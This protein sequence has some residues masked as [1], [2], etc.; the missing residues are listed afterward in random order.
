M[1]IAYR[2]NDIIF[3][4]GERASASVAATFIDLSEGVQH[5]GIH[6]KDILP[7]DNP[8]LYV[9]PFGTDYVCGYFDGSTYISRVVRP[10]ELDGV[11]GHYSPAVHELDEGQ[12]EE[13]LRQYWESSKGDR[14]IRK[15]RKRK[16]PH[17]RQVGRNISRL[18]LAATV[19]VCFSLALWLFSLAYFYT[20]DI[21]VSDAQDKNRHFAAALEMAVRER[22]GY[23]ITLNNPHAYGKVSRL[24]FALPLFEV[25]GFSYKYPAPGRP[26]TVEVEITN[27][28]SV[29]DPERTLKKFGELRRDGQRLLVEMQ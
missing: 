10:E 12:V 17:V 23:L 11:K 24:L 20:K 7:P 29:Y 6:L 9:M 13:L 3:Y 28:L 26:M 2:Y 19:S 21:E 25:S 8:G 18:T 15:R 5:S 4:K 14:R 16:I 27:S 1:K 22:A